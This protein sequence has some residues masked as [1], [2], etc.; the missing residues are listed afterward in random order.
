MFQ[1]V[2][3]KQVS[4]IVQHCDED[5]LG[6]FV[7]VKLEE[8]A[9]YF[10]DL[11]RLYED[12]KMFTVAVDDGQFDGAHC[13]LGNLETADRAIS[14]KGMQFVSYRFSKDEIVQTV[15]SAVL[16]GLN[17]AKE[18]LSQH[19]EWILQKIQNQPK[20]FALSVKRS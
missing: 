10:V 4:E 15:F 18:E 14:V 20:A 6:R 5:G 1:H 7:A 19:G 8:V 11:Q 9:G 16:L 17:V 12:K 2:Q 13:I 3:T